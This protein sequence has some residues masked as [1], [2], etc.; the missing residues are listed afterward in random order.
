MRIEDNACEFLVNDASYICTDSTM[1][2]IG[3]LMTTFKV[4]NMESYVEVTL[5]EKKPKRNA[6]GSLIG[7]WARNPLNVMRLHWVFHSR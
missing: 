6:F 2:I 1:I 7:I 5:G 3:F 4:V